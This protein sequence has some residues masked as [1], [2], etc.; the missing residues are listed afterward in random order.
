MGQMHARVFTI[1]PLVL[2]GVSSTIPHLVL[3][4][5]WSLL[6][7][8]NS[9]LGEGAC[10]LCSDPFQ[11]KT[12]N[13]K[14]ISFSTLPFWDM[15][16]KALLFWLETASSISVGQYSCQ[17]CYACRRIYGKYAFSLFFAVIVA[18][19]RFPNQHM[20]CGFIARHHYSRK[21]FMSWKQQ[22]REIIWYQ[23]HRK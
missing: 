4:I 19:V 3:F 12:R 11:C 9:C 8:S 14:Q 22:L 20:T 18:C 5:N 2:E 13:S 10:A 23:I 7:P 16:A 1:A 17:G 21:F 6:F 15:P